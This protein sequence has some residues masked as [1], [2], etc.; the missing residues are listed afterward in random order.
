MNVIHENTS[1]PFCEENMKTVEFEKEEGESPS[2]IKRLSAFL[3]K[4][5]AFLVISAAIAFLSIETSGWGQL[6][7]YYLFLGATLLFSLLGVFCVVRWREDKSARTFLAL[8]TAF[9]PVNFAQLGAFL[10]ATTQGHVSQF[11]KYYSYLVFKPI[12][13]SLLAITAILASIVLSF[14]SYTGFS[15]L[16]REKGKLLAVAYM[17]VNVTLLVPFRDAVFGS[18][19]GLGLAIGMVYLYR[20]R[21]S[22]DAALK[23][24][25]GVIV[26]SLLG[27]PIALLVVRN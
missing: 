14:V 11:S 24:A 1:I 26:R 6:E 20:K 19:L 9:V 15:A 3:R 21:I 12:S 25:D 18:F 7:R 8:A 16:A 27:A 13:L 4:F 10:L 23:S 5:G 2:N 22:N 17:L